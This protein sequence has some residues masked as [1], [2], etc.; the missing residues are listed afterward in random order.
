[1]ISLY[2]KPREKSMKPAPVKKFTNNGKEKIMELIKV[3][4]DNRTDYKPKK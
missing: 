3:N 4:T 2:I 1:M